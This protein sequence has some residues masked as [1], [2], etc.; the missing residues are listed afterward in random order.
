MLLLFCMFSRLY[1]AVHWPQDVVIGAIVGIIAAAIVCASGINPAIFNFVVRKDT[2]TAG[3]LYLVVAFGYLLLT[4]C[5]VKALDV[6]SDRSPCPDQAIKRYKLGVL[7]AL[8]LLNTEEEEEIVRSQK[9]KISLKVIEEEGSL[10]D[11]DDDGD[12]HGDGS[13]QNDI[14][15]NLIDMESVRKFRESIK[16]LSDSDKKMSTYGPM[17]M[18]LQEREKLEAENDQKKREK[19]ATFFPDDVKFNPDSKIRFLYNAINVCGAYCGMALYSCIQGNIYIISKWVAFQDPVIK[20]ICGLYAMIASFALIV[21]TRTI[22]RSMLPKKVF[23]WVRIF[24]YWLMG[25]FTY[26][27]FPLSYRA[28][29]NR[30]FASVAGDL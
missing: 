25:F 6:V 21:Y 22:L 29:R 15:T 26:G 9:Y 2:H 12:E 10:H 7:R 24:V 18:P 16:M 19:H 3:L 13:L 1:L 8:R 4:G 28:V 14:E 17:F 27:L 30:E 5:C 23:P 11:D 20:V